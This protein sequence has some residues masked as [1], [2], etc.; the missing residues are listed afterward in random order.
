MNSLFRSPQ[1]PAVH[2]SWWDT[3]PDRGHLPRCANAVHTGIRR[4]GT[5]F[6][7]S[8]EQGIR[9]IRAIL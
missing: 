6:D 1:L 2:H 7:R 8:R 4:P 3:Q 5:Q 9:F